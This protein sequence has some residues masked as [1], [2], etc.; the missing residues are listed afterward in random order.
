MKLIYNNLIPFKG[1]AAI[2]LF[3]I[4]FVRKNITL[5]DRCL[6]HERIHTIQG[7][8]M[9]WIFFYAWYLIEFL[10]RLI[11]YRNVHKAYRNIIFERETYAN[12]DDYG[13]LENRKSF[14]F[15]KYLK[16]N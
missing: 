8:E 13:Y 6:N 9:A 16:Q 12:D 3:G 10:I 4:L 14:A 15:L 2:N 1:F 5:T 11:Q 7:C